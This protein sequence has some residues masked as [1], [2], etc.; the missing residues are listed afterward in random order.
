[1]SNFKVL[2]ADYHRNGVSGDGFYIGIVEETLDGATSRKLVTYFPEVGQ[3]A[4]S[5]VELDKAAEGNIYMHPTNSQPGGNA[6]RGDYYLEHAEAI[7]AE[8]EKRW[9]V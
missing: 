6:W 9:T 4:I 1:M 8:V 3:C 7:K 2:E 5:V